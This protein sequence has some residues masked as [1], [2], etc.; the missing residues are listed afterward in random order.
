MKVLA[1]IPARGGSKGVPYKNIRDINGKPLISYTIE[2]AKQS[3]MLTDVIVASDSDKILGVAKE[4]D[5]SYFKRNSNNA[6]DNSPVELVVLELLEHLETEYDI[7]MLLQPTAPIREVYDIDSV[8]KMFIEDSSIENIVSV[9]RLED[10][11][12]GRMYRLS[13][14]NI[15]TPIDVS[16]ESKRRQDLY[17]VYIR[18]GAIYAITVKAF[19]KYK[20]LM[21]E[22][23]TPY[24]M[25][26]EK[27]LNIDS[28]RDL[29]IGEA[30]L[31]AWEQGKL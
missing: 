31:K 9:V 28:E 17:P 13:E 15:L 19:M 11:H 25:P 4:Y 12:P 2:I 18:N 3:H 20:K 23:K 29:I 7:I 14:E 24:L 10:I 1:I 30:L 8:I 16:L 21:L 6:E 5:C 22:H 27:W 26:E